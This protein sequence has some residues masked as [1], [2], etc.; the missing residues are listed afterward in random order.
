MEFVDVTSIKICECFHLG[1]AALIGNINYDD[2][3]WSGIAII[4]SFT[5]NK[6]LKMFK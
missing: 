1:Q 3:Y 5:I 4:L 2:R 6:L